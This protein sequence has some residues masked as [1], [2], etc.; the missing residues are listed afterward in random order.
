MH[1]AYRYKILVALHEIYINIL[2]KG[3]NISLFVTMY[4]FENLITGR[5]QL[6]YTVVPPHHSAS[7]ENCGDPVL[8]N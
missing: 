4:V 5:I 2:K 7:C 3:L 8:Y 1:L 6:Y